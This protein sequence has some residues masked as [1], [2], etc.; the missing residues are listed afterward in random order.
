MQIEDG[1]GSGKLAKVSTDNRLHTF[2]LLEWPMESFSHTS[3]AYALATDFIA[4]TT[5]ASYSGILY[6]LNTSTTHNVHIDSIRTSST[7]GALWQLMRNPTAGTLISAGTAL[8]PVNDNFSS[9]KVVSGTAKKG[10]DAQ[11]VTD[12]TLIGQW[13]TGVYVPQERRYEGALILGTG[14]SLAILCKPSA[15]A[16]IGSTISLWIEPTRAV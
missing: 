8:L 14:S 1:A 4:L 16:T 7:V 9:G 15:A 3:D 6:L 13:M 11:T 12:G 5:T 10:V 2:S